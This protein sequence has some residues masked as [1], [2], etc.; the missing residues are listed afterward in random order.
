PGEARGP[1][2][3]QLISSAFMPPPTHRTARCWRLSGRVNAR[4]LIVWLPVLSKSTGLPD[5]RRRF[6]GALLFR[7]V[8]AGRD[9][10]GSRGN[11]TKQRHGSE[12]R[13]EPPD[14]GE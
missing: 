14:V 4:Q 13:L 2:L 8:T 5:K 3:E 10:K 1:D 9:D 6:I 12:C 11:R 7:L